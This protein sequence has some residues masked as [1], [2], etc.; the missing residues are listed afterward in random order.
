MTSE[1]GLQFEIDLHL[2]NGANASGSIVPDE[3]DD[4]HKGLQ[5]VMEDSM[6]YSQ[7]I[8]AL[9]EEMKQIKCASPRK[10]DMQQKFDKTR[11]E[12]A[13][14]LN[15]MEHLVEE[16]SNANGGKADTEH[17]KRRLERMESDLHL[18]VGEVQYLFIF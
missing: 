12:M 17:L 11:K 4:L 5:L 15:M 16:H 6:S 9:Q 14:I 10:D 13:K 8:D 1:C 18:M 2:K 7:E 3:F